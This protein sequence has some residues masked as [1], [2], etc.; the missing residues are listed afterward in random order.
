MECS[1]LIG[2]FPVLKRKEEAAFGEFFSERKLLEEHE[3]IS[4]LVGT[5]IKKEE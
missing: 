3:R 2:T 1:Y 5:R 4:T